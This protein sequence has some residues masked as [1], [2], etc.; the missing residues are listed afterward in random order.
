MK[1]FTIWEIDSLQAKETA[2]PRPIVGSEN[3]KLMNDR[4]VDRWLGEGGVG[5]RVI[6][7]NERGVIVIVLFWLLITPLSVSGLK[8][9]MLGLGFSRART[10]V[11]YEV[12]RFMY[13]EMTK[14]KITEMDQINHLQPIKKKMGFSSLK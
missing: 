3:K 6:T 11:Q 2:Q 14:S 7:G 8:V 12:F 9:L 1:Y 10:K 4:S 13:I 5:G